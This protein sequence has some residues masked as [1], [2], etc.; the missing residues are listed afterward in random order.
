[1][2]LLTITTV[3]L[4][5]APPVW[6]SVRACN[7]LTAADPLS[8]WRPR[9][10]PFLLALPGTGGVADLCVPKAAGILFKARPGG[11]AALPA[12]T[13]GPRLAY[14]GERRLAVAGAAI[15][16]SDAGLPLLATAPFDCPLV[17][18]M[19]SDQ[20]IALRLG[21][22][23]AVCA[24]RPLCRCHAPLSTSPPPRRSQSSCQPTMSRTACQAL[25]RRLSG[26]VWWAPSSHYHR[27]RHRAKC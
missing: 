7:P 21:Q 9:P 5:G 12:H 19:A 20:P 13:A 25:W 2:D 17:W 24:L 27:H 1:M 8:P 15:V 6:L 14:A 10:L 4:V 18:P 26:R 11:G 16:A 3:L 23:V 22:T